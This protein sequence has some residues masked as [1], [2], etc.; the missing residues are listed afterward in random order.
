MEGQPV[1]GTRLKDE[2]AGV[3]ADCA[4]RQ[5]G[6]VGG[7]MR[8][9][10]KGALGAGAL[11]RGRERVDPRGVE[12]SVRLVEQQQVGVVQQRPRERQPLLLPARQRAHSL[13]RPPL[14]PDDRQHLGDPLVGV[15]HVVEPCV[16][17]EVLPAGQLVVEVGAVRYHPDPPAHRLRYHCGVEPEQP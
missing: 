5:T 6:G 7:V 17:A 8:G 9:D 14:H 12:A 2:A 15:R 1:T 4:G 10:D 16:E 13:L 3:E 11:D